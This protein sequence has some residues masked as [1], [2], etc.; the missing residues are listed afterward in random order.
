MVWVGSAY[1]TH[2]HGGGLLKGSQGIN[3]MLLGYFALILLLLYSSRNGKRQLFFHWLS[4]VLALL[5]FIYLWWAL[6]FTTEVF[7]G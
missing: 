1:A 5:P 7:K 3:A 2:L 4:L 6:Y